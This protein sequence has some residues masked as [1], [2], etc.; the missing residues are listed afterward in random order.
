MTET[1]AILQTPSSDAAASQKPE[2]EPAMQPPVD[3]G[4]DAE[5]ITLLADM[6]GVS[7][8]RLSIQVDKDSLL[9]EGDAQIEVQEGLQA[10]YADVQ[11]TRY[12]RSFALSGELETDQ[13]V[14]SLKDGVLSLRIPKS[15]KSRPRKIEISTD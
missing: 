11:S 1:A 3:I 12:R 4:E 13:I 15:A 5:G 7:K 10:L 2:K 9:I 14:A 6:P 8:D